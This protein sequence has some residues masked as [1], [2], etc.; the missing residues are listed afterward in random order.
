MDRRIQ[1]KVLKMKRRNRFAKLSGATSKSKE[2]AGPIPFTEDIHGNT[3][4]G[5]VR[6]VLVGKISLSKQVINTGRGPDAE[7]MAEYYNRIKKPD[8][9][10][11]AEVYAIKDSRYQQVWDEIPPFNKITLVSNELGR[12]DM[13]WHGE[14][15]FLVDLDYRKKI[16]KRSRDYGSRNAIMERLNNRRIVWVEQLPIR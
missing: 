5:K 9:R 1:Q 8:P 14:N 15:W 7:R 6:M 4:T 11:L 13:I 16:I 12:L 2:R 3:K 10:S